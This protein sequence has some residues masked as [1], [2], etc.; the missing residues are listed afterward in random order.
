MA[1]KVEAPTGVPGADRM[2]EIL[3]LRTQMVSKGHTKHLLAQTDMMTFHVHCYGPKGGENGLHAHVEEDHIFVCLQGEAQFSGLNGPLPPL[4]KNQALFL[5]KGCF[6]S[7]SNETDEPLILIRFGAS[8]KGYSS[9]RLD[10][11]GKP[12][13]GRGQ[14]HGAVQPI[15]IDGA[16]FE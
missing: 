7:F 10:P 5:P 6:Y 13:A 14:Q 12:I 15:L 1:T 16:F 9:S 4:K 8:P 11:K 2:P 3:S